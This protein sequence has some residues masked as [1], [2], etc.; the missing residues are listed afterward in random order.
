MHYVNI[1]VAMMQTVVAT[2]PHRLVKKRL[3]DLS[4]AEL[5][6]YL[7]QNIFN[8]PLT[9]CSHFFRQGLVDRLPHSRR[10]LKKIVGCTTDCRLIILQSPH[11]LTPFDRDQKIS[12]RV[13]PVPHQVQQVLHCYYTAHAVFFSSGTIAESPTE[14][15]ASTSPA[16]IVMW[17][18]SRNV[19]G[20][21]SVKATTAPVSMVAKVKSAA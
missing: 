20:S 12:D 1:I 16:A 8:H 15:T 6:F 2:L 5:A 14:R 18:P 11:E 4:R 13:R 21:R 7:R 17:N 19:A 10:R 3:L 9:P